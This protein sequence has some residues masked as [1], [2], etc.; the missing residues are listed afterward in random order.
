[1]EYSAM[2]RVLLSALAL[3]GFSVV[4][5]AGETVVRLSV[6]PMAAPKPALKY[7]LLPEVRE[8]NPGNPAQNY[9]KCF[10]EQRN[11]FFSKE[12]TA[13][14]ARYLSLPLAELP[15]EKLLR[16]GGSALRQADWAARLDTLDWQILRHVQTEGMDLPLP[17]LGLLHLLGP[18]L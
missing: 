17:E 8:L 9:L 7:Q 4:A 1:M 12:A 11:F 13:E 18:A 5:Q 15:A 2:N 6:Q 10:A 16:Y 3:A 14:R